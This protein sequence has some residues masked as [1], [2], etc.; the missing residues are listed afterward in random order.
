[1]RPIAVAMHFLDAARADDRVAAHAR[2]GKLGEVGANAAHRPRQELHARG[3]SA[4]KTNA[5]SVRRS[6][7][8][9]P[10]SWCRSRS[11]GIGAAAGLGTTAVRAG[12]WRRHSRDFAGRRRTIR[13]EGYF[14]FR[15]ARNRPRRAGQDAAEK[16]SDSV[17]PSDNA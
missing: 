14:Y 4:S 16:S 8:V 10:A 11:A 12:A 2:F 6:L 9:E 7:R 17:R 1:M 13:S 5:A 3:S 15:V